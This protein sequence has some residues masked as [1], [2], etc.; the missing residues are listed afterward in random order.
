MLILGK[1]QRLFHS[2]RIYSLSPTRTTCL[3]SSCSKLLAR[4]GIIK[5]RRPMRGEWAS[6]NKQTT[7][8]LLKTVMAACSRVCYNQT[9]KH[10]AYVDHF[11]VTR[12]PAASFQTNDHPAASF[13]GD[14][15]NN[16]RQMLICRFV[17]Q[18]AN[19][20]MKIRTKAEILAIFSTGMRTVIQQLY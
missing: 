10:N 17:I 16:H 6:A 14:G 2:L 9:N 5:L 8:W 20:V 18:I 15:P 12:N 7:T 3:S 1:L 13:W 11:C 19:I 4:S